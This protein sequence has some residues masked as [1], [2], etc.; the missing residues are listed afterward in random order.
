M[1]KKTIMGRIN[2]AKAVLGLL[3]AIGAVVM[4]FESRIVKA[5]TEALE[6]NITLML[7]P[8]GGSLEG[9]PPG[10]VATYNIWIK[11]LARKR[12]G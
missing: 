3:F 7:L 12:E 8:H 6:N 1:A 5:E 9:A 10:I 2:D 4:W 11:E